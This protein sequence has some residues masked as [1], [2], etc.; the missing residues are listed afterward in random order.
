MKTGTESNMLGGKVALVT[1]AASGIGRE[2]A[3]RFARRGAKVMVADVSADD[4]HK[5]VEAIAG[6]GGQAAFA[7]CDVSNASQ[8]QAAVDLAVQRF[9]RL[10]VVFANAGI[11]GVWAPLDELRPD[12]WDHTQAVN[13]RG[14]FLTLHYAIPHLREAGGGS[15]IICG[16]VNGTR[17]FSNAGAT[18][19]SASKAGQI[20]LMKH[21]ALE[22]GRDRIRVNAVCPG[23]IHTHIE[24]STHKR[25][26]ERID[27]PMT[28]PNGNPACNNG[29][30]EAGDVA[31]VCVFL[32]SDLSRHVSGAEIFVDGG[33][34]LL[35]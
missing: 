33:F 23:A 21:A 18:A 29:Q 6:A 14:T 30:G 8:V 5:V 1:G 26:V 35:R 15:V 11:N 2:T 12:E 13:L 34:S 9:G 28:L 24:R 25:D 32:A 16:S 17:T 3:L 10:D 22:L 19:Y 20:A 27:I 7:A 4:G 31:D